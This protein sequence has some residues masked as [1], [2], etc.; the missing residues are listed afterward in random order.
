MFCAIL[1]GDIR[2]KGIVQPL[3]FETMRIFE[4]VGYNTKEIILKEQHNC[5]ATGHCKTNS[6]KYDFFLPAHEYLLYSKNR[7]AF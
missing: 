2:R 3:A 5:K 1:M 7:I 6:I 4:L